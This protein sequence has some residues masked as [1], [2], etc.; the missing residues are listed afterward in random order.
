VLITH[1]TSRPEIADF[2][3][4]GASACRAL[5]RPALV[6]T[7]HADLAARCA[8]EGVFHYGHLPFATLMPRLGAVVHHGGIGTSAQALACGVP[9][10][11]LPF[12]FDR[13][14]NAARLRR[15]G[16]AD[17][18]PPVRWRPELVADSLRRLLESSEVGE[19]CAELARI[20]PRVEPAAAACR[21]I[22]AALGET[23]AATPAAPFG[24]PRSARAFVHAS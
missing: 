10:L 21:V 18:L 23:P 1:G 4:A 2:F 9:Q 24:E 19:R 17:S 16:G 20:R 15:L 22:E 12:G 14:D 11:I 5:G 13:P 7:P 6:V 8:G 3:D